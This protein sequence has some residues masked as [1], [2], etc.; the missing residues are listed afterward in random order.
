MLRE[1]DD[2]LKI[3]YEEIYE[4]VFVLLGHSDETDEGGNIIC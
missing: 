3:Q 4:H 2:S 1:A